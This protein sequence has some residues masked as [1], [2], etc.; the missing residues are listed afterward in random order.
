MKR[1]LFLLLTIFL[2]L[3]FAC[4][5][6]SEKV[7]G[8]ITPYTIKEELDSVPLIVV[9]EKEIEVLNLKTL[10]PFGVYPL[11]LKDFKE[12]VLI[13][14]RLFFICK[15]VIHLMI[16]GDEKTKKISLPFKV[17]GIS[18][19][20]NSIILHSDKSVYELD[21]DGEITKL[22]D[23][24]RDLQ[25]VYVLP[26]FS[27]II[28]VFHK[29]ETEK[30]S[31]F[32]LL[33]KKFEQEIELKG[34]IRTAISPFGKRIYLL[35]R[36]KLLFLDTKDFKVISEIPFKAEGVD[37]EITAS[38]NKIFLFT[39]NP[40]QIISIKRAISKIVS[41]MDVSETPEQKIITEDG[42]TI[43]FISKDI[44]YRFDTGSSQVVKKGA[45]EK[46]ADIL[47]TTERGSKIITG[48]KGETF[49]ELVDGN[50]LLQIKEKPLNAKLL[51]IICGREPFKKKVE[52]LPPVD[53]MVKDTTEPPVKKLEKYYTLQVSSSS[54]RDGAIKLSK[55]IKM[56]LI[57]V[58]ID[59][60]ELK[61][62]QRIYK[63]KVGA[64]ES[65]EDAENFKKGIKGAYDLSSWVSTD[66]VE[67]FI[68]K[69]AGVDITGDN[70]REILLFDKN[71]IL[72]FTN[73]G[74]VQKSVLSKNIE[75]ITFIGKPI[76]LKEGK[77]IVL[78]LPFKEDSILVIKWLNNKYEILKRKTPEKE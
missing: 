78:G 77:E 19:I 45:L 28:T 12:T 29:D 32:S 10:E 7:K 53:T 55:R 39:K 21:R 72:L 36:D 31:K 50:T 60:S 24:K 40:A 13:E 74:G 14:D 73:Y 68:L 57:P 6:T 23:F 46:R 67:T 47:L 42:G 17:K 9:T 75:G 43:F 66:M 70:N 38:E 64:F 49:L 15:E 52:E 63:V 59:S 65:R 48:K 27:S 30:L 22:N 69:E 3:P 54:V 35:T 76:T 25:E 1:Y 62:E 26:D 34:L 44:L 11:N 18:R 56:L 61:D 16:F 71:R 41:E 5:K 2:L 51:G 58:Y 37:F 8:K 20:M 33:S 4:K